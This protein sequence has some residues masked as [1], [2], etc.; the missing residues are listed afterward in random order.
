MT[1][2]AEGCFCPL[3][4]PD[5]VPGLLSSAARV[6]HIL[7]RARRRPWLNAPLVRKVVAA[8][9]ALRHAWD[10]VGLECSL[11]V[12]PFARPE[13]VKGRNTVAFY[14][15]TLHPTAKP[16][17]CQSAGGP[18]GSSSG[19]K[20]R[21]ISSLRPIL[22]CTVHELRSVIPCRVTTMPPLQVAIV[23][24]RRRLRKLGGL[25]PTGIPPSIACSNAY[26]IP[27]CTG[28]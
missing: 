5:T 12:V 6:L 19:W 23:S 13:G 28:Y 15:N 17:I 16:H 24:T 8:C 25:T 11:E 18:H 9:K 10:V 1:T 7:V 2:A 20:P 21:P 3:S 22:Q 14:A 26:M 4:A 27:S